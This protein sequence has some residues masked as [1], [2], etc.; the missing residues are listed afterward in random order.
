MPVIPMAMRFKN[1]RI[2]GQRAAF[3]AHLTLIY[4]HYRLLAWRHGLGWPHGL[5][6]QR[7]GIG[8]TKTT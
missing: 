4:G 8:L 2:S 6:L 7:I 1:S 3:L 5:M